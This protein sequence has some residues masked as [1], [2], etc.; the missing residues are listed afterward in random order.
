MRS[1]PMCSRS[2]ARRA[3]PAVP[4]EIMRT[5]TF[6]AAL[7]S[8]VLLLAQESTS[9]ITYQD[10]LQGYRNPTRW[11]TYSGDYSGQRHSPLKQITPDNAHRLSAKWTFQTGVIPRRGFEGTPLAVDDVLYVPGPFNN[12]WALDART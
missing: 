10:L 5:V 3:R 11:P 4:E 2:L 7:L 8:S 1:W 12:A 9:G 6:A